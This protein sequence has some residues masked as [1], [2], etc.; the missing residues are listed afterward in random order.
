MFK[1]TDLLASDFTTDTRHNN[2][3]TDFPTK[4][5]TKYALQV[6]F[7]FFLSTIKDDKDEMTIAR[8]AK[9][10]NGS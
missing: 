3:K 10:D 8:I 1:A 4:Q 2:T 6:Q 9:A 7:F 5:L